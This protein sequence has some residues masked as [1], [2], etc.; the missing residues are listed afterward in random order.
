MAIPTKEELGFDPDALRDNTGSNV[1]NDFARMRMINITRSKA[2]LVIS[3]KI[4][5]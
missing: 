2:N 5:I 4:P 1:I 3:L